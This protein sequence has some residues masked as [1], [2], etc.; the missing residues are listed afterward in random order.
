[1]SSKPGRRLA[2]C[3]SSWGR[4]GTGRL[5]NLAVAGVVAHVLE[6]VGEW[7]LML[8]A[9]ASITNKDQAISGPRQGDVDACSICRAEEAKLAS[10]VAS[11]DREQSDVRFPALHSVDGVD[12]D[13]NCAPRDTG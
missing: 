8:R 10:R 9:E 2:Y 6:H 1:M 12:L 11:C 4:S 13:R 3:S 5:P 7:A